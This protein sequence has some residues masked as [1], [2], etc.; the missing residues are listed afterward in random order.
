MKANLD[1]QCKLVLAHAD[2]MDSL[3]GYPH[4][5]APYVQAAA[6]MRA[7]V[8]HIAKRPHV[9]ITVEGGVVQGVL[10]D[11][12]V[13]CTIVDYDVEGLDPDRIVEI[14]QLGAGN[15]TEP[16]FVNNF[17]VDTGS[18]WHELLLQTLERDAANS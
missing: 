3:T 13:D 9:I 14:P 10:C 2:Y 17:P 1:D 8:A 15:T 4:P 12:P 5:H 16:A 11:Q 6:A 7:L 18:A